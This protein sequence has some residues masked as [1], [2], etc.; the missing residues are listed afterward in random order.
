[1]ACPL[2]NLVLLGSLSCLKKGILP[3][4]HHQ[5]FAHRTHK[6]KIWL[7][8]QNWHMDLPNQAPDVLKLKTK[9]NKQNKNKKQLVDLMANDCNESILLDSN[10]KVQ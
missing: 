1:M 7:E 9:Q 6:G 4:H 10:K 8:V 2:L 3:P 5:C